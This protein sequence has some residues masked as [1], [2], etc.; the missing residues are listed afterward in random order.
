MKIDLDTDGTILFKSLA[1]AKRFGVKCDERSECNKYIAAYF[2][3]L[4]LQREK[5]DLGV[6][7]SYIPRDVKEA[8]KDFLSSLEQTKRKLLGVADGSLN[9]TLFCPT[10]ESYKQ[11]QQ[12]T[13][14]NQFTEKLKHLISE[15]GTYD[16]TY[17]FGNASECFTL[18]IHI[19]C[20]LFS[21]KRTYLFKFPNAQ[22]NS[23]LDWG[24]ELEK[25]TVLLVSLSNPPIY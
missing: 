15:I 23:R 20:L 24:I 21:V 14:R 13:W 7:D 17:L 9:F 1:A 18:D 4:L 8:W 2:T 16:A 25:I 11:L 10:A 3:K 5:L 19:K 22:V 12:E 6:L